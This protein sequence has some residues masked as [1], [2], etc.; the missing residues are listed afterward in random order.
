R[1][2]VAGRLEG[3]VP[4]A[5]AL[6]QGRADRLGRAWVEVIDDRLLGVRELRLRIDLLEAMAP[7]EARDVRLAHRG[8]EVREVHG[9]VAGA[10]VV[11][12]RL[13]VPIG[14]LGERVMHT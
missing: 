6:E 2:A 12:A 4:P 7:E 8:R 3:L 9:T 13:V 5:R 10:R 1:V 14:Q 11:R